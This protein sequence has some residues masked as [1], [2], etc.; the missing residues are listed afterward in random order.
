MTTM[1]ADQKAVHTGT[2]TSLN[3]DQPLV[4]LNHRSG[5]QWIGSYI[6]AR[7]EVVRLYSAN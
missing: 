4:C 7:G 6:N 1:S 3:P 2:Q 5:P